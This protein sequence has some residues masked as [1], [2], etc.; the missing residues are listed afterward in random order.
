[1]EVE[2]LQSYDRLLG[3]YMGEVGVDICADPLPP[4]DLLIEVRAL[5]DHGEIFTSIGGHDSYCDLR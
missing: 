2:Y 5:E 4:L 3:E 1:M